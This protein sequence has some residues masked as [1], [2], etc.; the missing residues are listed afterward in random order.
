MESDLLAEI[1]AETAKAVANIEA[2]VQR[3]VAAGF[4]DTI[5]DN[6][7]EDPD[8]VGWQRFAKPGACPFCRMLAHKGAVYRSEATG[9]FAAHTSCHC[10]GRPKFRDGTLGEEADAMQYLASSKRR[11]PAQRKVLRDYLKANYGA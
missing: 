7:R 8:A 10:V 4:W 9:N 6:V 11:T 2:T 5:T 3:E 1:E